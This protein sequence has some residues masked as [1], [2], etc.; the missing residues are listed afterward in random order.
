V[1]FEGDHVAMEIDLPLAGGF[2]AV[3]AA[4]AFC[5]VQALG[6]RGVQ[7]DDEA[8]V[9]GLQSVRIPGRLEAISHDPLVLLDGAHN[10]A[11]AH[12]L[13]SSLGEILPGRRIHLV[14]AAMADKDIGEIAAQLGPLASSMTAT[15]VPGTDRSADPEEIAGAFSR[16]GTR[17]FVAPDP[18]AAL[19]CALQRAETD[20]AVVVTG[21]MYLVGWLQRI[22]V[23]GR[24]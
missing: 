2:Q 16:L 5:I 4:T 21:S 3:N 13:A 11:A 7:I 24:A 6:R 9:S 17:V 10:P 8:I 12:E 18:A 23:P 20:D 19:E 14:L 15:R 1:R 22:G